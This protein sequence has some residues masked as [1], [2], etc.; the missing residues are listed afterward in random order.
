MRKSRYKKLVGVLLDE[1]T[2]KDIVRITDKKDIAISK[3]IRGIVDEKLS[4]DDKE[5]KNDV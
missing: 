4:C 5:D 2:Y 1:A 3:Y